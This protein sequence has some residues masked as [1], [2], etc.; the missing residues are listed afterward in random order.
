ML[1][2]AN[3]STTVSGNSGPIH[4]GITT[5]I[6]VKVLSHFKRIIVMR[7]SKQISDQNST[8]DKI[9]QTGR[10]EAIYRCSLPVVSTYS[11]MQTAPYLRKACD[12]NK[13]Q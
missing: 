2:S 6:E 4:N 11:V 3:H 9:K 12:Q 8:K 1:V 13:I 10:Q 7:P 5:W